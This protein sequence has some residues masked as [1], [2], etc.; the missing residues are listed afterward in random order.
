MLA[1][2]RIDMAV[3]TTKKPIVTLSTTEDYEG[4]NLPLKKLNK[5]TK[6]ALVYVARNEVL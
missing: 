3:K 2:H 5:S 4:H 1:R 6:D